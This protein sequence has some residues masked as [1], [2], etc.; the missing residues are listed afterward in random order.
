MK[1]FL[2][3]AITLLKKVITPLAVPLVATFLCTRLTNAFP[4]LDK[5]KSYIWR[6]DFRK[7]AFKCNV[8]AA[9]ITLATFKA[10]DKYCPR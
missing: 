8:L 2:Q 3:T 9:L 6:E 7:P 4:D 1:E 10:I 5:H